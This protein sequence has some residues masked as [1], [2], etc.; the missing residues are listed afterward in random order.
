MPSR[1]LRDIGIWLNA[2]Q[3][4]RTR[5]RAQSHIEMGVKLQGLLHSICSPTHILSFSV[6]QVC[7]LQWIPVSVN[8]TVFILPVVFYSSLLSQ[9]VSLL[10]ISLLPLCFPSVCYTTLFPTSWSS[11]LSANF[12]FLPLSVNRILFSS[13]NLHMGSS[14]VM[15]LSPTPRGL[16]KFDCAFP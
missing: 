15:L 14:L 2:C 6:S 13:S 7:C 4:W 10:P 3:I 9:S 8:F 1:F 16:G 5:A 11:R 12:S